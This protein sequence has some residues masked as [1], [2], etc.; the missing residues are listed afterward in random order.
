M[1]FADAEPVAND[2]AAVMQ[3][4]RSRFCGGDDIQSEPE[5][6]HTETEFYRLRS[7]MFVA[8]VIARYMEKAEREAEIETICCNNSEVAPELSGKPANN[9]LNRPEFGSAPTETH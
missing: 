2:L 4:R 3:V 7:T 6:P 8:Q 9:P 5:W 1:A